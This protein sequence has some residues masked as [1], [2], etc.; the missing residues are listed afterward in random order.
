MVPSISI[1]KEKQIN[2]LKYY[3]SVFFKTNEKHQK[4]TENKNP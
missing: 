1:K 2:I 4:K 3:R